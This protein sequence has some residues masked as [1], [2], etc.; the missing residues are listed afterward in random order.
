MTAPRRQA[1]PS[2]LPGLRW[3]RTRARA[4]LFFEHLWPAL[5]PALGLLG[6]ALLAAL[7]D[8]PARLPPALHAGFLAALALALGVLLW[9]GGRGLT[10]PDRQAA[11]RRLER[12]SGLAHRPLATLADQPAPLG[13]ESEALWRAHRK[14]VLT[15]IGRLRSGW[16]HPGLA[17]RD[18]FALRAA[19]IVALAAAAIIAGPEAPSRIRRALTPDLAFAAGRPAP[20]LQAWITPPAY[21]GLAPLFLPQ[22]GGTPGGEVSV[23]AGSRLA[24][25]LSGRRAVPR[26]LFDG[27]STEFA[28]LDA[29]SFQIETVLRSG[30]RLSVRQGWAERG[31]WEVTLIPATPPNVAFT[32]P[33]GPSTAG[34]RPSSSE[35]R[36]PELRVPWQASDQYG[37]K[38]LG[39]RLSLAPRPEAPALDTV[40][41][42][43]GASPK[44]AHATAILDLTAHPWAGLPVSAR[45]VA[46]DEAGLEATSEPAAFTLPERHFHNP[47]AQTL[48]EARKS[49][50]LDPS[51]RLGAIALLDQTAQRTALFGTDYGGWLNYR[52]IEALL[53][54]DPAPGAIGEA[55][56]RMWQLALHFEEGRTGESERA[57]EAARQE[58]HDALER[59]ATDEKVSPEDIERLMQ[60]FQEALAAHLQAL[61]E[62]AKKAAPLSAPATRVDAE[63]LRQMAERMREDAEAGRMD[64]ARAEM[65]ALERM[66]NA[67]RNARAHPR[68]PARDAAREAARKQRREEEGALRELVRQ[69]GALLDRAQ[70][71][72]EEHDE[73]AGGPFRQPGGLP[74]GLMLAP[75]PPTPSDKANASAAQQADQRGETALR[76]A[77]QQWRRKFGQN[78]GAQSPRSDAQNPQSGGQPHDTSPADL[79]RDN[80]DANFNEADM[81]MGHAG[82]ELGQGED[83]AAAA[84]EQ[85]ALTALMK[86]GQARAEAETRDDSDQSADQE[87]E[88]EN[89][90]GQSG[91]EAR[92]GE[93]GTDPNGAGRARR[94]RRDPLGRA[95]EQGSAG[96]DEAND[97]SVPD[98]ME[99]ARSRTIEDELRRRGG[100][101]ERPAEE[102]HYIDRLLQPF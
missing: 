9:R 93:D 22:P 28:A 40:L 89:Q 14:A 2:S 19:L 32:A 10:W 97:V 63:K 76:H 68:D 61:A 31:A 54:R 24:V 56:T 57:L 85:E 92:G 67:L 47:I 48:A 12:A 90:L 34:P 44:S 36:R 62:D 71:R 83:A 70:A 41:P 30:G 8:L 35:P 60:R 95:V 18:R 3:A 37:V 94:L 51:A 79:H 26:L 13:A 23:P 84:A 69:Q 91:G 33:P 65:R 78:G 11:E 75:R 16:P 39:L 20:L 74:L 17:R 73:G 52:A 55:Q 7:L 49:L 46:R 82:Q 25:T 100:E 99:Q 72:A 21:T 87:G 29:D 50:S 43:P 5:W 88:G 77:L 101:R 27:R 80:A 64:E 86:G 102:L 96:A 53:R 6:L 42:L 81:A 59:R 98:T 1:D 58:L 38:A 15:R 66:L 4:V 45:L